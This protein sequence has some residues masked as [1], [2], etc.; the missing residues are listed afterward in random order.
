MSTAASSEDNNWSHTQTHA[1]VVGYS[2]CRSSENPGLSLDNPWGGVEVLGWGGGVERRG[3]KGQEEKQPSN[4][5]FQ[6]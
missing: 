2:G 6:F 5:N 4:L 1:P 3:E